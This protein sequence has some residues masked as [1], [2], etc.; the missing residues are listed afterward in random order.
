MIRYHWE[1]SWIQTVVPAIILNKRHSPITWIIVASFLLV[2]HLSYACPAA[3]IFREDPDEITAVV[4]AG[5]TGAPI[6]PRAELSDSGEWQLGHMSIEHY[7]L[8][9]NLFADALRE[10]DPTIKIVAS[11]ATPFETGTTSRHHRPP[12]PA[13][14][15]YEY[16]SR[17]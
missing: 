3:S 15:P 1:I 10:V 4:H 8:K 16:G 14:L 7:I 11:G 5:Q 9:H 13:R 6:N 2:I 12:L 17:P